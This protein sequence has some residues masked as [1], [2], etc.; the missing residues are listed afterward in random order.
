M[1]HRF[2]IKSILEKLEIVNLA[3]LPFLGALNFLDLVNVSLK[4]VLLFAIVVKKEV[5]KELLS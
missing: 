4:K 2:Y 3:F 5:T 1:S